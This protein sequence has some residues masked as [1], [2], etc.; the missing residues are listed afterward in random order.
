[1]KLYMSTLLIC[2]IAATAHGKVI[3][4][5]AKTP[6]EIAEEERQERERENKKARE[7]YEDE[8]KSEEERREALKILVDNEEIV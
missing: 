6:S 2:L 3:D 5:H 4:I 7:I 1:M 8:S